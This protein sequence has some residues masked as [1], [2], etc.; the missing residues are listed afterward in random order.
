[1]SKKNKKIEV[2]C[3]DFKPLEFE[4]F[5]NGNYGEFATIKFSDEEK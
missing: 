3:N 4:G 1:M 5:R 2:K